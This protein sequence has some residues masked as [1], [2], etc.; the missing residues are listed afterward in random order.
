MFNA[1]K[2]EMVLIF[3]FKKIQVPLYSILF[4]VAP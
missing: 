4:Y 1:L 3:L 2:L